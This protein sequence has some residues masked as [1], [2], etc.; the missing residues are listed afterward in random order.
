MC[1]IVFSVI[2]LYSEYLLINEHVRVMYIVEV[3][4]KKGEK[5]QKI[6]REKKNQIKIIVKEGKTQMQ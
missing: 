1:K 2:P 3:K 5:N 6:K 4:E